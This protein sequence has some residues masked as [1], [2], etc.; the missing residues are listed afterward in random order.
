MTRYTANLS[1][2][3]LN[4][5]INQSQEHNIQTKQQQPL[6]QNT[7][8][9]PT[10]MNLDGNKYDPWSKGWSHKVPTDI[11]NTVQRFTK[12]LQLITPH[13]TKHQMQTTQYNNR[14][15]STGYGN[16]CQTRSLYRFQ[17]ERSNTRTQ[18]RLHKKIRSSRTRTSYSTIPKAK[19]S[20]YQE[21]LFFNPGQMVWA[22]Y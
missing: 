1:T 21:E 19:D 3:N 17:T 13:Q 22:G 16:T 18:I 2:T 8:P 6:V 11:T 7:T 20:T 5:Q 10:H 14:S 4:L 12:K 9:H 15:A